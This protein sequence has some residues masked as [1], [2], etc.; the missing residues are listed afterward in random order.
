MRGE[1]FFDGG[2]PW[3]LHFIEVN[4]GSRKLRFCLE[5][6]PA[7]SP[8]PGLVRQ[9]HQCA[10]GTGEAGQPGPEFEMFAYIF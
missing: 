3:D 5:E 10:G 8:E 9:H 4:T 2:N 7:V 1:K 6:V